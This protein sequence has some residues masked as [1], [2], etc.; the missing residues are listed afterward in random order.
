M[1]PICIV[2]D[3]DSIR[4]LIKCSIEAGGYE[5]VSFEDGVEFLSECK[6]LDTSLVILDIMLPNIS[7]LEILERL[8][9]SG[10]KM[11]VIFLT[12]KTS[13]VDKVKGL[14]LGADD[15]ITKPFGPLELLARVKAVLRRYS[16]V[17]IQDIT[18][19]GL[20]KV[21]DLEINTESR[22]VTK[23]KKQIELTFKEYEVLLFLIKYENIAISRDVLLDKIW[24]Y[25][26]EGGT[27]TVDMHIKSIRHKL[28]DDAARPKY[29]ET[30]RGYGYRINCGDS[31]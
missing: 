16:N 15:Y 30:V 9:A 12:A 27:R 18:K 13:E 21:Q 31:E 10:F 19:R 8:R 7:G 3:D 24:G 14:E 1:R 5:A 26:F 20:I 11:P 25:D 22:T 28:G 23:D 2:E 29:I 4:E 6:V 17:E